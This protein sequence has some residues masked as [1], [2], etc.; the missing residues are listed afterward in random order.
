MRPTRSYDHDQV[1][2]LVNRALAYHE[3]MLILRQFYI[4]S[5][6]E[7]MIIPADPSFTGNPDENA[8]VIVREGYGATGLTDDWT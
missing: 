6:I 8:V 5:Y 4:A 3:A 7:P 1:M 2:T